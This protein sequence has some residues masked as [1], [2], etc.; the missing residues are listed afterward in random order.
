APAVGAV[1]AVDRLDQPDAADLCQVLEL[2]AAAR[3]ALRE[4]AHEADVALDQLLARFEVAALVIV[5]DQLGVG[6]C[7]V[8]RSARCARRL[9]SD[10]GRS[11]CGF[12]PRALPAAK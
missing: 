1:E 4:P 12:P 8:V 10:P 3:V 5:T 2:L 6:R 9:H 11:D 7:A